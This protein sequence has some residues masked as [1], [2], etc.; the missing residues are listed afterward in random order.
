ML[1]WHV[2]VIAAAL[3]PRYGEPVHAAVHSAWLRSAW[4]MVFLRSILRLP[5]V[6][7]PLAPPTPA[8]AAAAAAADPARSRARRAAGPAAPAGEAAGLTRA[9]IAATA[10]TFR[11]EINSSLVT[12]YV[13]AAVMAMLIAVRRDTRTA[14]SASASPRR[15]TLPTASSACSLT[16]APASIPPA[17]PVW[18]HPGSCAAPCAWLPTPPSGARPRL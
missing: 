9:A 16:W 2:A 6:G 14:R 7:I 1:L 18:I 4:F 15:T 10:S 13:R 8:G 3:P 5:V 17:I 12:Y 11:I